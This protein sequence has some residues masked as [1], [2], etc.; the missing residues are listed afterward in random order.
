[1]VA[2][3]PGTVI[4]VSHDRDFL[5]RTVTSILAA[6]GDGRWVEYAGG[7]SDMLAQRGARA[8]PERRKRQRRAAKAQKQQPAQPA[9]KQ[10]LS[11]KD[12]HALETL[13]ATID[14]LHA[15]IGPAARATGRPGPVF[16]RRRRLQPHRRRP[17]RAEAELAAAEEEWLRL[18]LLRETVEG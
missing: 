1:M 15:E 8:V 17:Q 5:D 3:Y 7:Y 12:K 18:E 4:L 9:A 2:D 6:E 11:F 13:P 10:K 16:A 14:R